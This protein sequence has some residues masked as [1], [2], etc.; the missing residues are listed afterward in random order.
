MCTICFRKKIAAKPTTAS[1][2]TTAHK[3]THTAAHTAAN[4]STHTAAMLNNVQPIQY[5]DTDMSQTIN[6]MNNAATVL[7]DMDS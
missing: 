2:H 4:T 1:D 6:V 7:Y 3:T 5:Q